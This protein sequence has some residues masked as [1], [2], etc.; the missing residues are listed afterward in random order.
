MPHTSW[1]LQKQVIFITNHQSFQL[2]CFLGHELHHNV[3]WWHWKLDTPTEL[4]SLSQCQLFGTLEVLLNTTH[5]QRPETA[6]WRI[7]TDYLINH[8]GITTMED[9][10]LHVMHSKTVVL[11]WITFAHTE[12]WYSLSVWAAVLPPHSRMLE[13]KKKKK[14]K[15]NNS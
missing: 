6:L 14:W 11:I 1:R 10:C 3:V 12:L 5:S 2:E 9:M 7:K 4:L 8:D 15:C 13:Q